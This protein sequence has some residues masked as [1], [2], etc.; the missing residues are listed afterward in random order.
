MVEVL[1]NESIIVNSSSVLSN[2]PIKPETFI[3]IIGVCFILSL[4]V[5]IGFYLYNKM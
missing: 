4:A 3:I 1:V 5:G 2:M